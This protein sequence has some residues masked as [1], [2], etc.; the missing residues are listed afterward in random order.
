MK[1][2]AILGSTGSIGSQALEVIRN[3]SNKFQ[4]EALAAGN[5]IEILKEQIKEFNPTYISVKSEQSANE[6][7]KIY[8]DK[9]ILVDGIVQIA[10]EVDYDVILIAV[11]GISGLFPTLE[12]IKRAKTIAL[13]N[14]ET[15]VSAGE[16]V[17]KEA[18]KTNAQILPVDS[19]HSAIFQC[20][21]NGKNIKNLLITASGGPFL[22]KDKE[23]MEIATKEQTL[24]HPNWDMGAKITVDSA[25]LMNKGLEV[26]EAHHLFNKSYDNIKV[27]IHPQ[28]IIHSAVEFEDGSVISQMGLPSMHIPI[29]YALTYPERLQGIKTN[30]FDLA[31][32]G[33]LEFFEPDYNKFPALQLAF[34]VGKKG[35]ILP[36]VMNAANEEAVYAF[37]N[38]KIKLFEIT[39]IT[40]TVV[41]LFKNI[42]QPSL[43]EI[44]K[45]DK[46]SRE[47]TQRLIKNLRN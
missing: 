45:A 13:A 2:I 31:K 28:S 39:E 9:K 15:L 44:L 41:S 14:K 40:K 21:P 27:V 46:Q 20:A 17:M 33:K 16:I 25:T 26:I 5:N 29:Q 34:E 8:P 12:A 1:K 10:K 38:D 7:K 37:L 30:S 36:A 18:Q 35:G 19:E 22:N 24:A 43:E 4:V 32:I 42:N 6:L 23:I 47:E 11:T 3:L